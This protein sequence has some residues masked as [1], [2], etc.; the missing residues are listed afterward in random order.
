MPTA[1]KRINLTVEKDLL[2][3]LTWVA[4]KSGEP[5][6]SVSLRLIRAALE[7]DEDF[8]LSRSGDQRLQQERN[9]PSYSH[10][11]AWR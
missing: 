2:K 6:S 8:Y 1:K 4:Q 3:S 7:L 5:I 10:A 11:H 9:R